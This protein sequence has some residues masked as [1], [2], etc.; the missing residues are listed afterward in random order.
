MIPAKTFRKNNC[1]DLIKKK[2]ESGDFSYTLKEIVEYRNTIGA[3]D[4]RAYKP[5]SSCQIKSYDTNE[6]CEKGLCGSCYCK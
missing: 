1:I 2:L 3:D 6:C 4:K 5:C